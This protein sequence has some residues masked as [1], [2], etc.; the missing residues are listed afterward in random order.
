M[1]KS[2]NLLNKVLSVQFLANFADRYFLRKTLPSDTHTT[3][4]RM[5][6]VG[7]RG[8]RLC[9]SRRWSDEKRNGETF[10]NDDN[11]GI[12]F[13]LPPSKNV[14]YL[15]SL[16]SSTQLNSVVTANLVAST[17]WLWCFHIPVLDTRPN[18]KNVNIFSWEFLQPPTTAK[19]LLL[20]IICSLFIASL[21]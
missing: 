16:C 15:C 9:R 3:S 14:L 6:R 4:Q 8:W 2:I 20:F 19:V 17:S 21:V 18:E 10:C 7:G 12:V 11:M 5:S 13:K 1:A